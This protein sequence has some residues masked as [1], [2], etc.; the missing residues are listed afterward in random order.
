M[1]T[2]IAAAAA[3]AGSLLIIPIA[4]ESANAGHGGGFGGGGMGGI[5]IGGGGI[6]HFSGGNIGHFYSGNIGGMGRAHFADAGGIGG[7]RWTGGSVRHANNWQGNWHGH[8]HN[9]FVHDH[10]RFD[11]R[12]VGVGLG[13]WPAYYAY[14]YAYGGCAWLR[15]QALITG[16]PYWWNR[17]YSC[18]N[19]Y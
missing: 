12:F 16:S 10:R 11:N 14:N 13:W 9:H 8:D 1:K 5:H 18:A 2:R 6:G 7:G 19:Y 15:H 17:Y 3:F 4:L